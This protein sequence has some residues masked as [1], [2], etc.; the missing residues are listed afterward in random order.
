MLQLEV[1]AQ[2]VLQEATMSHLKTAHA[3]RCET[4][5]VV[6]VDGASVS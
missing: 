2:P 6:R 3:E 1:E 4:L 5:T